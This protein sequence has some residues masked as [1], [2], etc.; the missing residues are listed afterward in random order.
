MDIN[1]LR[2]ALGLKDDIPDEEVITQAVSFVE[3][4]KPNPYIELE[5]TANE[6]PAVAK[7]LSDIKARDRKLVENEI[8]IR[9]NEVS[10][11]I[12][13]L[14]GG[15]YGLPVEASKKLHEVLI[16]SPNYLSDVMYDFAQTIIQT[17]L[18]PLGERGIAHR[19]RKGKASRRFDEAVAQYI[20]DNKGVTYS[21]ASSEISK[22]RPDL[23]NAYQEELFSNQV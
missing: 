7:M 18:V 9:A 3:K 17:G 13:S 20:E 22:L 5:E 6:S 14:N 21:D 4:H 2:E 10:N 11:R 15:K 12:N 8:T 16:K 19:E 1:K 23:W